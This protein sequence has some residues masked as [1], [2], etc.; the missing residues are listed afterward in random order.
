MNY[1]FKD[2]FVNTETVKLQINIFTNTDKLCQHGTLI[3]C[4]IMDI[5]TNTDKL[6]FSYGLLINCV[7]MDIFQNTEK[8]NNYGTVQL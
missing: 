1:A 5:F 6:N 2:M 7:K 4:A 8:L 3:N